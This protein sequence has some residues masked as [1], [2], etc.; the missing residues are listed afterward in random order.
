MMAARARKNERSDISLAS[1]LAD[2]DHACAMA[3][4][5]GQA[6]VVLNA[7]ALR[8]KLGGLLVDQVEHGRPGDFA[9]L[10]SKEEILAKVRDDLGEDAELIVR[11]LFGE[12]VEPCPLC[13]KAI[14]HD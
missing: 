13:S 6:N 3:E 1:V 8:A 11:V 5:R 2:I 10:H 7:A 9:D 12:R 14:A 4:A